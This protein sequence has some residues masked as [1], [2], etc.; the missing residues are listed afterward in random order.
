MALEVIFAPLVVDE[1]QFHSSDAASEM[2]SFP[3]FNRLQTRL[4]CYFFTCLP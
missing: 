2:L 1:A 4:L 3:R